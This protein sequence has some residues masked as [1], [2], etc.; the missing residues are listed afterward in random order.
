ML[1]VSFEAV[2]DIDGEWAN[3]TRIVH[4]LITDDEFSWFDTN[5]IW[6]QTTEQM[7]NSCSFKVLVLFSAGD[8]FH[9]CESQPGGL[10]QF[11]YICTERMIMNSSW[12]MTGQQQDV[13]RNSRKNTTQEIK[14]HPSKI[15][16]TTL[17][18]SLIP[19]SPFVSHWDHLP[20]LSFMTPL[21]CGV[22]R[23]WIDRTVIENKGKWLT[24]VILIEKGKQYFFSI[25]M[26]FP[27]D[28]ASS[29]NF[30]VG[31]ILFSQRKRC[32]CRLSSESCGRKTY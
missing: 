3:E 23:L 6:K 24:S 31:S 15:S 13:C 25:E 7:T 21:M 5:Q 8:Y 16:Y 27:H 28:H 29:L 9:V 32:T 26:L 20:Q 30:V 4:T 12:Y 2:D 14:F 11:T 1:R 19:L 18:L 10:Q 17:S 22:W